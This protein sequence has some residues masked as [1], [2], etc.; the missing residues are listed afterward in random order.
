MLYLPEYKPQMF[1]I[2]SSKNICLL[3]Y[4]HIVKPF[5]VWVFSCKLQI[6][7]GVCIICETTCVRIN[8]V[9]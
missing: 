3:I 9:W 8:K 2:L 4:V 7:R 6:V 5:P 1:P